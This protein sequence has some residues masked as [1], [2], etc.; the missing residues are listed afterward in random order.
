M[1][2]DVFALDMTG[3]DCNGLSFRF[4]DYGVS[5]GPISIQWDS[6]PARILEGT[7]TGFGLLLHLQTCIRRLRRAWS[8]S[9]I[10]VRSI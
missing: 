4:P 9:Q 10:T 7:P 6:G 8:P 3:L 1:I 2:I 5:N